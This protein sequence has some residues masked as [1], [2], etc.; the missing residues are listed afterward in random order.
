[1]GFLVFGRRIGYGSRG[2]IPVLREQKGELPLIETLGRIKVINMTAILKKKVGLLFFLSIIALFLAGCS[3]GSGREVKSKL[4]YLDGKN[5]EKSQ[6]TLGNARIPTGMKEIDTVIEGGVYENG[7][8]PL[9]FTAIYLIK[10]SKIISETITD[11]LG[12]FKLQGI[13]PSGRYIIRVDVKP[14]SWEDEIYVDK[15]EIKGLELNID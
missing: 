5:W 11:H 15:S 12:V 4:E 2:V 8:M 1:M 7:M 9:K 3:G 10:D 13:I 14:N 6:F